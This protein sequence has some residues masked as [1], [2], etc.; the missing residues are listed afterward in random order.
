MQ[1]CR[2]TAL[3]QSC[4][5]AMSLGKMAQWAKCLSY[6]PDF[7]TWVSIPDT[8]GNVHLGMK[9][10][11]A[12]TSRS[13]KLSL[14]PAC[15]NPWAPNLE[16]SCLN[17][18]SR[19]ELR[20]MPVIDGYFSRSAYMTHIHLQTWTRTHRDIYITHTHIHRGFLFLSHTF[21]SIE[22]HSPRWNS[23]VLL[24]GQNP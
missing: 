1:K 11:G 10:E 4:F 6:F 14:H 23:L 17:F 20:K 7:R 18:Q 9:T 21:K 8:G 15:L 13:L 2:C 5:T 24:S 22:A 16:R 19:E 12:E 3:L